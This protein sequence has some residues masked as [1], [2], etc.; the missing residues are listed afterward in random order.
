MID[1]VLI[2]KLPKTF[3]HRLEIGRGELLQRIGCSVIQISENMAE[4]FRSGL[5]KDYFSLYN[6]GIANPISLWS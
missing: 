1:A 3:G 4:S 2:K 5:G 6:G